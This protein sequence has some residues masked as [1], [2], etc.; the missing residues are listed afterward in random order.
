M[1]GALLFMSTSSHQFRDYI[2]MHSPE[3]YGLGFSLSTW[4]YRG[5][6]GSNG[7]N[8]LATNVHYFAGKVHTEAFLFANS[9]GYVDAFVRFSGSQPR[10]RF[11]HYELDVQETAHFWRATV[12]KFRSAAVRQDLTELVFRE[13]I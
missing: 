2:V 11:A 3:E 7:Y 12:W 5:T 10:D 6:V 4:R 8:H 1:D 9:A 13:D